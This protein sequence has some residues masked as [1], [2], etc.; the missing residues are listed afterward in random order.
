MDPSRVMALIERR[1]G[2]RERERERER[3]GGREE[4]AVRTLESCVLLIII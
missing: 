1:E 2:K 3:G 4:V